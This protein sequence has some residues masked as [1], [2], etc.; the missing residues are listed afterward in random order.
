VRIVYVRGQDRASA[1]WGDDKSYRKVRGLGAAIVM[2]GSA[3]Q[4]SAGL[5]GLTVFGLADF[6]FAIETIIF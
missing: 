1:G 3:K 5:Y 2:W 6:E 4:M